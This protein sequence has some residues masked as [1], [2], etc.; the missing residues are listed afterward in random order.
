[1]STRAKPETAPAGHNLVLE[2]LESR[3]YDVPMLDRE[4]SVLPTVPALLETKFQLSTQTQLTQTLQAFL[5]RSGPRYTEMGWAATNSA[6]P[7]LRIAPIWGW[8]SKLKLKPK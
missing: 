5:G 2:R 6:K 1:M 8:I 7:R 3:G 4:L